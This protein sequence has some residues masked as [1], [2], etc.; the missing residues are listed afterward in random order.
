MS[1]KLFSLYQDDICPYTIMAKT[2][3]GAAGRVS[4]VGLKPATVAKAV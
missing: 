4:L 1:Q 3:E 2:A